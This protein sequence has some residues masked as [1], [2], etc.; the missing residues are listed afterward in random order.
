MVEVVGTDEKQVGEWGQCNKPTPQKSDRITRMCQ[1]IKG[2]GER[3]IK[4][5]I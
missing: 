4:Y 2:K 3:R 1:S 5:E